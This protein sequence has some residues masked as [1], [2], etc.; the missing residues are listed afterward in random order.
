MIS[1]F[2]PTC[3]TCRA[4]EEFISRDKPPHK[5]AEQAGWRAVG[6]N[7]LCTSCYRKLHGLGNNNFSPMDKMSI[8]RSAISKKILG[9]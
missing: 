4:K 1:S 6:R 8:I 9:R 3:T 7:W 2:I 5:L